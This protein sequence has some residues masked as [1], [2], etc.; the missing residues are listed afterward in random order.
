M[1]ILN[2]EKSIGPLAASAVAAVL[3]HGAFFTLGASLLPH[4]PEAHLAPSKE[5]LSVTLRSTPKV[6][7]P[8]EPE[9]DPLPPIPPGPVSLDPMPIPHELSNAKPVA[10]VH[11]TTV[12][13]PLKSRSISESK[14]FRTEPTLVRPPVRE[15]VTEDPAKPDRPLKPAKIADS[16]TPLPLRPP[17]VKPNG[18]ESLARAATPTVKEGFRFTYPRLA[19]KHEMEGRVTLRIVV[20]ANGTVTEAAVIRSSGWSLLDDS[21]KRQILKVPFTPAR[22]GAGRPKVS[23]VLKTVRFELTEPKGPGLDD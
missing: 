1:G 10:K 19:R 4:A 11:D 5:I 18:P 2:P 7:P 6:E 16:L 17:P 14:P 12:P 3:L 8:P 13:M 22:D 15:S 21:A 23:V 9:P 20:D